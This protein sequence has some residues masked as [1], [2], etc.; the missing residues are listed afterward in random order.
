MLILTSILSGS[1]LT[2]MLSLSAMTSI[3]P[4]MTSMLSMSL[5]ISIL[6][7]SP[8]T[9]TLTSVFSEPSRPLAMSWAEKTG[10]VRFVDD[11]PSP[12]RAPKNKFLA[13]PNFVYFKCSVKVCKFC[14]WSGNKKSKILFCQPI[15]NTAIHSDLES[16]RSWHTKF[17]SCKFF[18]MSTSKGSVLFKYFSFE[19]T[20]RVMPGW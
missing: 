18:Q 11:R 6:S 4:A 15:R 13:L 5:L 8:L 16:S 1:A 12:C 2:S 17:L 9:S 3:L 14:V 7:V 10:R 19:K 20:R